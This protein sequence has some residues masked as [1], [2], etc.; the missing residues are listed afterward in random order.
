MSLCHKVDE[1]HEI[2]T[3]KH[4]PR[5]IIRLRM[6]TESVFAVSLKDFFPFFERDK[7]IKRSR[8]WGG[9]CDVTAAA[10]SQEVWFAPSCS[11]NWRINSPR[12]CSWQRKLRANKLENIFYVHLLLEKSSLWQV[13]TI[14]VVGISILTNKSSLYWRSQTKWRE[15][16]DLVGVYG[17][18]LRRQ[19]EDSWGHRKDCIF[20]WLVVLKGALLLGRVELGLSFHQ[21][22]DGHRPVSRWSRWWLLVVD[23][24]QSFFWLTTYLPCRKV[25]FARGQLPGECKLQTLPEATQV[26]FDTPFMWSSMSNKKTWQASFW[27]VNQDLTDARRR[28]DYVTDVPQCQRPSV[29]TAGPSIFGELKK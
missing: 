12:N 26:G 4:K 15:V 21:A 6:T 19:R 29:P 2:L 3:L 10:N 5:R 20:Y 18:W 25:L 1:I 11:P 23:E 17:G 27:K 22:S 8:A 9:V 14:A 24:L 13:G 7:E 28:P 16:G